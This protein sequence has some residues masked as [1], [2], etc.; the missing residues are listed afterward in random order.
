M[1]SPVDYRFCSQHVL[2]T[3]LL[4]NKL[5]LTLFN[6]YCIFFEISVWQFW[7]TRQKFNDSPARTS[8]SACLGTA[9]GGPFKPRRLFQS[10]WNDAH[11]PLELYFRWLCFSR[12]V[13]FLVIWGLGL[14][15]LIMCV[16]MLVSCLTADHVHVLSHSSAQGPGN[17]CLSP[18][19]WLPCI[20]K[21]RPRE[22]DK[23]TCVQMVM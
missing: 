3:H 16:S 11:D 23:L 10:P 22:Y 8:S 7:R 14:F 19:G 13:F 12:L 2:W 21:S 4:I 15:F 9:A 5:S 6:H 18:L 17:L 1:P 20:A